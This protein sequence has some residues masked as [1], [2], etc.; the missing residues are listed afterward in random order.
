MFGE[1]GLH[2]PHPRPPI[3]KF[4]ADDGDFPHIP[5]PGQVTLRYPSDDGGQIIKPPVIKFRADDGGFPPISHTMAYPSDSGEF[6]H[7]PIK[8]A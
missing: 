4:R 6:F 8:W 5:G 1:D 3:I 7:P 2:P